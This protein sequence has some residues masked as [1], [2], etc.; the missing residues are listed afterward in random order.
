[1]SEHAYCSMCDNELGFLKQLFNGIFVTYEN[2]YAD[3]TQ[4]YFF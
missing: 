3:D 2:M 1:M 4:L